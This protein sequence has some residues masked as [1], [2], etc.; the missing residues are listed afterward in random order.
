MIL[1]W[2][3]NWMITLGWRLHVALFGV[4]CVKICRVHWAGERI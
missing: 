2:F 4:C 1:R 3:K